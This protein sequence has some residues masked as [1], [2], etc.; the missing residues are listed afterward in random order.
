MTLDDIPGILI[1]LC[2]IGLVLL[3]RFVPDGLEWLEGLGRRRS[4]PADGGEEEDSAPLSVRMDIR[5]T[6]RDGRKG[7]KEGP[8]KAR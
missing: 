1:V 5:V 7:R 8:K 2:G 4:A 3:M 6:G